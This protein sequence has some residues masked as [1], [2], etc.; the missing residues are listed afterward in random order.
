MKHIAGWEPTLPLFLV[1][2]TVL[3][4]SFSFL[5]PAFVHGFFGVSEGDMY[6]HIVNWKGWNIY[7]YCVVQP[8]NML[9]LCLP[10]YKLPCEP[11][12]FIFRGCNPYILGSWNLHFS[13]F[14]G[15]NPHRRFCCQ[16]AEKNM[17]CT[18]F[19]HMGGFKH[20]TQH[21]RCRSHTFEG[22]R[23]KKETGGQLGP[24]PL[25]TDLLKLSNG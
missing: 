18:T 4:H 1:V 14:W 5:T 12:P 13:C 9:Y 2:I 11:T 7:K 3:T 20:E 10:W 21:F 8:K 16:P 25:T 15:P 19:C 17:F 6:K 24:T 22:P 23:Q